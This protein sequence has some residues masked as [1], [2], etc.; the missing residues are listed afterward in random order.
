MLGALAVLPATL[1]AVAV[2][3]TDPVFGLIEA[4]RSAHAVHLAAID[5]AERLEVLHGDDR[6]A[7]TEKP[8]HDEND[9]FE[10]LVL[11]A[12]TSLPGLLAKLRYF[13][14]IAAGNEAWMLE[15]RNGISRDLIDSFAG[16]LWT[17]WGVRQ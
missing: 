5:E 17:I 3:A 7:I 8:F 2:A 4:H 15:E 6:G 16:S 13:R 14:A 9:A 1:P 10:A 11:A 12:A